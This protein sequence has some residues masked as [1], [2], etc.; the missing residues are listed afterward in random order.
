[1]IG[2]MQIP[3]WMIYL[4]MIGTV[5]ALVPPTLV[6]RLRTMKSDKPRIHYVQDMDNQAR[7][8]AQQ[9]NELFADNRAGRPPI[10]GTVARGELRTDDHL[11]LGVVADD[12]A[13]SYPVEVDMALLQRGQERFDIYCSLCHGKAGYG[14]G[15]VHM[16]AMELVNNPAIGNGTQWVQ[17]KSLHD[18]EVRIQPAGQIYNTITN[19]IRNMAGYRGQI[20]VEDRWAITAYVQALQRSQNARPSD[21]DGR[22]PASLELRDL[23]PPAEAE[24]EEGGA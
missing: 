4:V 12:W 11:Q 20:P 3:R 1:M 24:E 23:M 16:R 6:W 17:P 9:P 8:K 22:D 14:D 10:E 15:M 7:F 21:L 2:M 13:E 19:G 5:A 18:P